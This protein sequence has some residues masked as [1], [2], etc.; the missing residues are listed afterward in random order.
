MIIGPDGKTIT[1]EGTS[2]VGADAAGAEFPW[3]PKP[4][5]DLNANPGHLNDEPCLCLLMDGSEDESKHAAW[6]AAVNEIAC[7]HIG[8]A[9]ASGAAQSVYF[10]TAK[11]KGGVVDQ[12]RKL[13]ELGSPKAE[14]AMIL[15]DI[16]D[17]GGFYVSDANEISAGSVR[18]FLKA[19]SDKSVERKQLKRG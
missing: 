15:L 16:A 19:Y 9:E 12:V 3:K 1:T 4:V 10:Y 14:P 13:T 17:D 5:E 6:A 7:E 11:A 2:A 18:A 8:A